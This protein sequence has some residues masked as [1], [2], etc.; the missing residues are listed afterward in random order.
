MNDPL[1]VS[2]GGGA[3]SFALLIGLRERGIRPDAIVFADTRGEKPETERHLAEVVTPWLRA[4]NFPALT[5]LCR[6]G[7][8]RTRVGDD[9]LEAE[10][11]RLGV[12]PSRAYGRGSCADKWKI[13]PFLW[14]A[15]EWPVAQAAW[16]CG[17]I[18]RRTIGYDADEQHRA[19]HE[20]DPGFSKWYP[21]I[22]WGW[23][24]DDC[25]AVIR[26]AGLPVPVKSACFFCPSSTKTEVLTL[27]RDHPDLFTRAVALESSAAA[28]GK[29]RIAGLGRRWSWSSLV[30]A[31]DDERAQMPEAPV[32][33]CTRCVAG[34]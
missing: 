4:S 31:S 13:D 16:A 34:I 2:Y 22:E 32:E 9:S 11:L 26:Q 12:L 20:G 1:T 25:E 3:N 24:R 17:Q 30:Q 19:T 29:S 14:W 15:K 6:A 21:L 33:A 5:V 23:D 27:Y 7:H 18:V 8:A 28:S 10:C